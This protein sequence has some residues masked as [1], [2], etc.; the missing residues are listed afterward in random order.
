VS[1]APEAVVTDDVPILATSLIADTSPQHAA[2]ARS[3]AHLSGVHER[4]LFDVNRR[5]ILSPSASQQPWHP[6]PSQAII[7]VVE[8]IG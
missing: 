2:F 6:E 1:I 8:R 3:S 4:K 7:D 5:A